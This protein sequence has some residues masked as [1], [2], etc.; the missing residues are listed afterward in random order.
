LYISHSELYEHIFALDPLLV[1]HL[2]RYFQH[3]RT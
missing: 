3:Q 2:T 1:T